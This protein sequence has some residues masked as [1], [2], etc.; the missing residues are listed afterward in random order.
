MAGKGGFCTL[1]RPL[2]DG[3]RKDDGPDG[4]RSS[5]LGSA[6]AAAG[7]RPRRSASVAA[8]ASAAAT[9]VAVETGFHFSDENSRVERMLRALRID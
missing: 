4:S 8:P 7:R 6:P 9:A 3:G 1:H 5:A 2:N